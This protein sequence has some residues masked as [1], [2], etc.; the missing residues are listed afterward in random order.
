MTIAGRPDAWGTVEW[1]AVTPSYFRTLGI[2]RLAGRSFENTD[3]AGGPPVAIIN[4]AFARR[5]FPGES[6]IGQRIDVG[7]VKVE[8]IDPALDGNRVEI[9]GVV[10][11]VRDVS[12]RSEP[13]RTMYVP[14]AQA[15]T[16]LS[17]LLGTMPVFIARPGST[18]A[19]VERALR[20]TVLAAEPSLSAPH[21]F[22][23]D[24]AVT[25]SLARERF[26]ATLLSTLA[27]LALALTAL[28]IHGVL[29]YTIQQ[30]RREIGI[31]MALG[32]GAG[33]VTRLIMVQGV[34]PVLA[35]LVL[36]I[37]AALGLSRFVA[38]FLWGVT[39]TDP[40]TLW[41]VAV[42]LL[43]VAL[44]ASWIPARAAAH[45]DPV[46]TLNSE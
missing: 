41:T 5:Y 19:N 46:S 36:G 29:A 24:N 7:R 44:A 40:A 26:G 12:L 31:R 14:Q 10:E 15:P 30:R 3:A 21:V 9:V 42:I 2:E 6:P 28:G 27:A 22:P 37:W 20:E 4:D 8:V 32:A 25:R 16:R 39:A 1:R 17:N 45:L 33:Q 38:G 13:R 43:G 18:G 23:L 35:G 11:D 34:A